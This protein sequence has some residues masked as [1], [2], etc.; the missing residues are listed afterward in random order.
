MLQRVGEQI[1]VGAVFGPGPCI[2]PVWFDWRREKHTIEKVTYR[3]RHLAGTALRLHFAVTDG[4]ALSE[5]V[6]NSREQLWTLEAA[7]AE[8]L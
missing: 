4:T 7:D 2:H 6:Y 8:V 3:W 5:L 1:R